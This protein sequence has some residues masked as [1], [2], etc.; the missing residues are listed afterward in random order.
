MDFAF[1]YEGYLDPL[2][3]SF[4]TRLVS[5]FR[6]IDTLTKRSLDSDIAGFLIAFLQE[7][8]VRFD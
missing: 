3:T 5:H 8:L 6:L 1:S 4:L 7:Y 2:V